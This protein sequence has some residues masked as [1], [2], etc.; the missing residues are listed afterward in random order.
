MRTW[1]QRCFSRWWAAWGS[2]AMMSCR[3]SLRTSSHC[4]VPGL[5]GG[6]AWPLLIWG[7][8]LCLQASACCCMSK[9]QGWVSGLL[10]HDPELWW[11]GSALLLREGSHQG[12]G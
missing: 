5:A 4:S 7:E 12:K 2:P 9:A 3:T 8:E 1:G 10:L 11:E 6:E